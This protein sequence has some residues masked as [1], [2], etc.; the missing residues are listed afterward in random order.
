MHHLTASPKIFPEKS[1]L[2]MSL[3][4]CSPIERSLTPNS[5]EV[6]E[7][8]ESVQTVQTVET[9]ETAET[10]QTVESVETVQTVA[11]VETAET[12]ETVLT[13]DLKK[14]NHLLTHSLTNNLKARDASAPKKL[15]TQTSFKIKISYSIPTGRVLI[16]KFRSAWLISPR[17]TT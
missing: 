5:H 10:V 9:V 2:L 14:S 1:Q 4:Y 11:T 13:E 6:V 17:P 16:L 3:R 15:S 7:T 8:V 12:E